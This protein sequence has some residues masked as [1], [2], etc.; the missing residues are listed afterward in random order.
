MTAYSIL[1][2]DPTSATSTDV[3]RGPAERLAI[4]LHRLQHSFLGRVPSKD[5]DSS[6][7][8]YSR[9]GDLP[10]PEADQATLLGVQLKRRH[11]IPF[12]NIENLSDVGVFYAGK[13][14]AVAFVGKR[15]LFRIHPLAHEGQVNCFTPFHNVNCQRGFLYFNEKVP[16]TDDSNNM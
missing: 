7:K 6:R 5:L 2:Y 9:P 15:S 4:R 3:S 12:D 1:P 16:I 11:L 14:P 13:K 8:R 10:T